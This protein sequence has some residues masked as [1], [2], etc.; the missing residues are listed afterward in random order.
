VWEL[1]LLG[2]GMGLYAGFA[3]GPLLT[4]VVA[5]TLRA[6]VRAG[7]AAALAPLLTDAPIIMLSLW[8]LS[9]ISNSDGVL[10]AISIVGAIAVF[11]YGVNGIRSGVDTTDSRAAA[12]GSLLRGIVVNAMSPHPYLFWGTVG[13]PIMLRSHQQLGLSGPLVFLVCFFALLVGGKVVVAIL[14]SASKRYLG[15]K[16]HIIVMRG[17]GLLLCGFALLLLRDGVRLLGVMP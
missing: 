7:I 6:G 4:L 14:T 5:E 1:V 11:Y 16:G 12:T 3:P 9:R 10:G 17:S 2:L 15:T 8:G 13:A